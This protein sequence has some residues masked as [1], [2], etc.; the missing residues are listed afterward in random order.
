MRNGRSG[1]WRYAQA[2]GAGGARR[3]LPR[4]SEA[5]TISAIRLNHCFPF[6]LCEPSFRN[7]SVTRAVTPNG[8]SGY[9]I[10]HLHPLVGLQKK[11]SFT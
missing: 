11:A 4:L 1:S 7:L 9:C 5:E 3:E 2:P 10:L 6:A 8:T